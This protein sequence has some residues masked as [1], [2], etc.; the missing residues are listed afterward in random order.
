[1]N[2]FRRIFS[3]DSD[4]L[5]EIQDRRI[6]ENDSAQ[7]AKVIS[8]SARNAFSSAFEYA[9]IGMALVSPDGRWLAKVNQALCELRWATPPRNC[10]GRPSRTS[11]IPTICGPTWKMC[12]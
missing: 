5:Q 3:S 1:M 11:P 8:A 10:P 7:E 12:A 2:I 6:A 9:A 4:L